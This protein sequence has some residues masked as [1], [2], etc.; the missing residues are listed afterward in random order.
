MVNFQNL[1]DLYGKL[2]TEKAYNK[3]LE[4]EARYMW[5]A[6]SLPLKCNSLIDLGPGRGTF[7]ELVGRNRP[8]INLYAA[9]YDNFLENKD[10][11]IFYKSDIKDLKTHKKF[12]CVT[13]LDVLEH[14]HP[15]NINVTLENISSLS[16]QFL[17]SI[18]NHSDI[19]N[20]AELHL[21]QQDLSW[22]LDLLS[23]YFTP[24]TYIEQI[25]NRLF[26]IALKK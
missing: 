5:A 9:D 19:Q 11:V 3:H 23:K 24:T 10:N 8:E 4:T 12:D 21:I 18:A 17:F 22:W 25:K 15:D 14:I 16:D 7:L 13:C 20:G 2:F 1:E 6:T 26:F